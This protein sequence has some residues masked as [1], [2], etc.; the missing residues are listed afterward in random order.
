MNILYLH[1]HD[2]GRYNSLYGQAIQT[3]NLEAI[4]R[5]GTLFN[6]AYCAGPT[7]SPSRSALLTGR[8][9]PLN[10]ML[11][12][13]HRG[14]SLKD[15]S[16][17]LAA[18]LRRNGYQT[19]LS[20]IQHEHTDPY[21]LGYS[22]VLTQDET[23]KKTLSATE[24]DQLTA[25][26]AAAFIDA[27]ADQPLEQPFF[28]SVGFILPHRPYVPHQTVNPN[29]VCPPHCL[30]NNRQTREDFADYIESVQLMD[31][32]AGLVID[33]LKRSG[34]WHDTLIILTTDHGIAFPHMK[35]NL[36]DTGIGV[37]L[38]LR[39]PGREMPD[40][41]D[42]LVSQVDLFPTMCE[43]LELEP[44]E[45]LQGKSLVPLLCGSESVRSEIFAGVTYH[46]AYEPMR[47][48]RTQRHKLIVRYDHDFLKFV[49]PNIDNSPSKRFLLV[50]GIGDI[51]RRPAELYDLYLDPA[52]RNNLYHHSDYTVVRDQLQERLDTFM[53]SID[54]PLLN[55]SVSKPKGAVVN[56]KT[57]IHPE[58]DVYET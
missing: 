47:C 9:P 16:S 57:G 18:F 10:G 22:A 6:Q 19:V 50:S 17:H 41:C 30:P 49:L 52:E 7:C 40:S 25:Q 36:Y 29:R 43:L 11:G 8:H 14:F 56:Q 13:A 33:A 39:V 54:D 5:E 53:K 4:A 44:P 35:C 3:P 37:T 34:R 12:L 31:Q 27:T 2:M 20:G 48:I 1:A 38:V 58:D 32:Q 46:A 24:R 45:G 21:A 55:G 23:P 42:A 51:V 28:L 26:K 15:P